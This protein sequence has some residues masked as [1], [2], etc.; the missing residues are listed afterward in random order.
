MC[1][2]FLFRAFAALE[3]NIPVDIEAEERHRL[4]LRQY[5]GK[6]ETNFGQVPDPMSFHNKSWTGESKGGLEK[7]PS[8]YYFDIS[9][10]LDHI[11]TP[12]ELVHRLDCEYK[13]GKGYRYYTS[14]FVKEI[15][16]HPIDDESQLCFLKCKV[17]PSQNTSKTPYNV[18]F[19]KYFLI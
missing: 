3:R 4:S 17:T 14:S 15:F 5:K 16:W 10:Y 18:F 6:L 12:G 9:K 7:W 8:L 13:E 11:N 19:F 2:H 1:V